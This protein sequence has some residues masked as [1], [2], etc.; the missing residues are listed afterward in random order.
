MELRDW[1]EQQEGNGYGQEATHP[2]ENEQWDVEM[3]R[4]FD[5]IYPL[6]QKLAPDTDRE[7]A[8]R[9]WLAQQTIN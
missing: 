9:L 2:S 8:R 6:I 1:R 7:F 3:S 4:I 5:D